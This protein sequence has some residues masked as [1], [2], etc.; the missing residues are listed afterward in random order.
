[1]WTKEKLKEELDRKNIDPR[2]YSLNEDDGFCVDDRICFREYHNIWDIFYC[3]RGEYI[4]EERFDNENDACEYFL[5]WILGN[6]TV[7]KK[8]KS[9]NYANKVRISK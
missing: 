6:R 5:N 7:Y 8:D 3:E 4:N 2:R 9:L 1:M